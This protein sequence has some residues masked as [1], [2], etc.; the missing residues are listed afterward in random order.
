MNAV[1]IGEL[2]ALLDELE[3]DRTIVAYSLRRQAEAL[4]GHGELQL[5]SVAD[6]TQRFIERAGVV[7]AQ[8]SPNAEVPAT[9]AMSLPAIRRQFDQLAASIPLRRLL[10]DV[11]RLR[12]AHGVDL[13]P[14][15]T[16]A[17]MLQDQLQHSPPHGDEAA[18]A[19]LTSLVRLASSESTLDD[20]EWDACVER[21]R[22]MFGTE[23]SVAAARGRLRLDLD[24]T[25]ET[26]KDNAP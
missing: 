23:L 4:R 7:A 26:P 14:V 12:A 8:V 6:A 21:V 22:A 19:A 13:T 20:A 17:G 10:V 11:E 1:V 24:Q 9:E 18:L 16:A 15:R 3:E 25:P 5:A 2:G